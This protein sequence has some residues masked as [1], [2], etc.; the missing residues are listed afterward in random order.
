M[1][2]NLWAIRWGIPAKA[3]E[4]LRHE[5]GTDKKT[6]PANKKGHLESHVQQEVRLEASLR[7]YRLFRNN[8]GAC[9]DTHGNFI[10]YGL[11]NDSKAMN[12]RIKSSD[13]I[14]IKPLMIEPR[15]VGTIVGQFMARE[16]KRENW[17]YSGSKIEQAQLRF[18]ELII[19]LGGDAAFITRKDNL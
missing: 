8:L 6:S 14:G 2:L 13:L 5:M 15:H 19:S 16:V 4:S 11:A 18:I 12:R 7:G 17:K 1:D 9:M 10:R 3:I